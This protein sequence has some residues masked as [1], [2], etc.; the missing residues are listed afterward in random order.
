MERKFD[1]DENSYMKYGLKIICSGNIVAE[2]M[3]HDL[4]HGLLEYPDVQLPNHMKI[5]KGVTTNFTIAGEK[6]AIS[7]WFF[8]HKKWNLSDFNVKSCVIHNHGNLG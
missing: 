3:W 1:A 5:A 4:D 7:I 8:L 6:F 2:V